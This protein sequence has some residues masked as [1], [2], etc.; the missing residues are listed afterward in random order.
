MTEPRLVPPGEEG[1]EDPDSHLF[2][3]SLCYLP[4]VQAATFA[5]GN[6]LKNIVSYT[7]KGFLEKII[8]SDIN[9]NPFDYN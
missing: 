4:C 9:K 3:D 8:F 6:Y 7:F 2:R 1:S 5:F